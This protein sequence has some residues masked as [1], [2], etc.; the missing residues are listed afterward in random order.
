MNY[1]YDTENFHEDMAYRPLYPPCILHP[2]SLCE[3]PEGDHK[4]FKK[5]D[6]CSL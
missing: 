6:K 3:N 1:F 5:I 4:N 2:Y